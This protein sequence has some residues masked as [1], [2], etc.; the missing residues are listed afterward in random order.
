VIIWWLNLGVSGT[1]RHP[2]DRSHTNGRKDK[3]S[4]MGCR[5]YAYEKGAGRLQ[6]PPIL[7]FFFSGNR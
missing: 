6:L 7:D 1:S 3:V 4:E 2:R 5:P